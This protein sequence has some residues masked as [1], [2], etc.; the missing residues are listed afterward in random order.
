MSDE[1]GM[2]QFVKEEMVIFLET[3]ATTITA[4]VDALE[5]G[6]NAGGDFLNALR[7]VGYRLRLVANNFSGANC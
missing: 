5:H 6:D 1:V 2:K 3:E 7:Q 4:L